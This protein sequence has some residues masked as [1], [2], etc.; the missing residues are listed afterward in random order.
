MWRLTDP[1]APCKSLKWPFLEASVLVER[2]FYP[3][4]LCEGQWLGSFSGAQR[5]FAVLGQPGIGKSSF[6]V[7]LLMQQLRSNCTVVYSRGST[8]ARATPVVM[9]Y[10][11]HAGVAFKTSVADLGAVDALLSQPSVV[12]ICDSLPPRLGDLC[13]Q[14]LLTSPDPDVWRWFV[15]KEYARTAYFP[16]YN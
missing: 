5:K 11:F 7:W 10:V 3:R 12:H 2:D 1:S 4:F 6:G 8:K 14:V 13:H 16:L 9:H 15:M